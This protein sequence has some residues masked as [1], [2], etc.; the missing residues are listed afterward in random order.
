MWVGYE[1]ENTGGK[2]LESGGRSWMRVV[3]LQDVYHSIGKNM[4]KNKEK[5]GM[6]EMK[7]P[8]KMR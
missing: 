8:T 2:T 1:E 3:L 5:T 7:G 4:I 6:N